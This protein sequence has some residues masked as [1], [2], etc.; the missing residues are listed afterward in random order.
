VRRVLVAGVGNIFLG[1]DGFGPAVARRLAGMSL[2]EG[3]RVEDVGIRGVHLAYELL[4]GYDTLVLIDAAPHGQPPGTVSVIEPDL[5]DE[6]I[7]RA[8]I[9]RAG[10]SPL[11][12]A[13]GMDPLSAFA[14]LRSLGG[15]VGRVLVV[16]C[17]PADTSERME[18]SSAVAAAVEPTA[19]RVRELIEQELGLAASTL[20]EASTGKEGS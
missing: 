1:D 8:A 15:E 6:R 13:H 3:V 17:E 10:E 12:D 20:E 14:M 7:E 18:L 9:V 11:V 16:A 19:E 5:S 2:P 4:E